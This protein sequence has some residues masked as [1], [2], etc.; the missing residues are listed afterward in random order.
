MLRAVATQKAP[1]LLGA[2]AVAA[3]VTGTTNETVLATVAIPAGAMGTNGAIQ[4]C[5]TWSIT[6][7]SNNKITRVRLGGIGGTAFVGVTLTTT[8]TFSDIRR[9]RNRNSA[10]SQVASTS[11]ATTVGAGVTTAAVTTGTVDTSVAQDLVFTGQLASAAET[12][13]LEMYEVW[14]LPA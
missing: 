10:S 13:T 11:A 12:I 8:V 9:V 2:S 4:I 6:N 7:S 1:V 5:A 3:S 14:L